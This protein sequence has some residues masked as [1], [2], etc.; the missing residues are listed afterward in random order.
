MDNKENFWIRMN[1]MIKLRYRS[2]MEFCEKGGIKLQTLYNDRYYK[3]YPSVENLMK[4]A[5]A[6]GVSIDYLLFE[7]P[8]MRPITEEEAAF[9]QMFNDAEDSTKE[10]VGKILKEMLPLKDLENEGNHREDGRE[11]L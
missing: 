8:M 1:F 6:L 9:I 5:K 3:R 7:T 4:M 10:I 11:L 2:V